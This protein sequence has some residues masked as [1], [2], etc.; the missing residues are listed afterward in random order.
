MYKN[1]FKA[2]L[3]ALVLFNL[4]GCK[5]EP[6]V[7]TDEDRQVIVFFSTQSL[8]K[9]TVPGSV[10]ENAIETIVLFG[11]DAQ[12]KILQIDTIDT[13]TLT[14]E[15]LDVHRGIEEFYA[16][17]NP[18]DELDWE[19]ITNVT[20]LTGLIE[21]FPNEPGTPF[22]G[23][24]FLMSGTG[25]IDDM[26][27]TP[28]T[29][30]IRLGR[31]VAKIEIQGIHDFILES[32]TVFNTPD[33]GYVFEQ[34]PSEVQVP[35]SAT[36]ISYEAGNSVED[37][38]LGTTKV[39]LYVAENS[40]QSPT[41]FIVTGTYEDMPMSYSIVL[42]QDNAVIDIKRNTYYQVHITVDTTSKEQLL[43]VFSIADWELEETE[44][45]E[46]E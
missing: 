14:G 19:N 28:R 35:G 15:S 40:A 34:N 11:V 17:A 18:S 42:K 46:F 33:Q 23:T 3:V 7:G 27:T 41:Q 24:P 1:Y 13:P 26:N 45:Q 2:V 22:P 32:V 44:D 39:T 30:K 12:G 25:P 21:D 6:T 8:L 5:K 43:D 29:A 4:A 16:I 10:E 38:N 36:M 37:D 20:G 31:A 9:A